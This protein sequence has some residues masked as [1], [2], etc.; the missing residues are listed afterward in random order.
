MFKYEYKYATRSFPAVKKNK[1]AFKKINLEIRA[2][3][4]Q[5]NLSDGSHRKQRK[6]DEQ[7]PD[8]LREEGCLQ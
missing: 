1:K 7:L 6:I 2:L 4:K 5:K 3:E 8:C